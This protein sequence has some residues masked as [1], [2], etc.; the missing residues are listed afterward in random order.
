MTHKM[1]ARCEAILG[2]QP[3]WSSDTRRVERRYTY[4]FLQL[5]CLCR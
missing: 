2:D 1:L 5:L 4:G 3:C